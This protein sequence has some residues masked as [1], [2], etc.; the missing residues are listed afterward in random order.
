MPPPRLIL[1]PGKEKSLLRRHPWIFS[2]AVAAFEGECVVGDTVEVA[3]HDGQFLAQAAF[4]PRSQIRARVWTFEHEESVDEAFFHRRVH[5]A[6]AA[7][8]DLL[9]QHLPTRLVHAEADGLPGLI[10]DRYADLLVVQFLTV[11][12]ERHRQSLIDALRDATGLTRIY[13]RSDADV[14]ALEGLASVTGAIAGDP[15]DSALEVVEHGL[16]YAV[17]VVHGQKTGF[18]I[19]QRDSR[20]CLSELA[21]GEVLNCFCYTGGFTLAA[22]KAGAKA[23]TSVDSSREAIALA[24]RNLIRN[25]FEAQRASWIC[26]DVFSTLRGLRDRRQSFDV[27]I[28]DPPKFAPTAGHVERAARAYKDINLLALK[29]LRPGGMLLTFSCSGGV[30]PDLFQKILAGAAADAQ[31]TVCLEHRLFAPSDHPVLLSFP[32]GEYLKGLVLRKL[33]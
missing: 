28:L 15:P 19:D 12:A 9:R 22:L 18:Y 30:S 4:S 3:S 31:A 8:A 33:S 13:E 29:L 17:D 24:Q 1:K 27:V 23:V 14:R 20:E 32:E 10:V 6:L 26:E 2:G 11:G 7:R 25:G 5:R 16:V 21:F